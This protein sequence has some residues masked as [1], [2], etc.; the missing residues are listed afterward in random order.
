[1]RRGTYLLLALLWA[2]PAWAAGKYRPPLRQQPEMKQ[3]KMLKAIPKTLEL[4]V[5]QRVSLS[6]IHMAG[7]YQTKVLKFTLA[8]GV[9][10]LLGVGEGAADVVLQVDEPDESQGSA[11]QEDQRQGDPVMP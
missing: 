3:G 8:D 7:C 9:L 1:M 4:T 2:T 10:T 5:G 11:A 6:G